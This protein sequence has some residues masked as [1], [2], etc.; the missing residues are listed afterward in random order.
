MDGY[1]AVAHGGVEAVPVGAAQ[2]A[3]LRLVDEVAPVSL[4]SWYLRHF[5]CEASRVCDPAADAAMESARTAATPD[6]RRTFLIQADGTLATVA[7]FIALAAPPRWSLVSPRL[8]GFRP[9]LF[10]RHPA[11]ELLRGQ[12]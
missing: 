2:P 4:A 5:S 9:N 11:G 10:G 6:A 1:F 12:Q 8:V 3:D 7:P